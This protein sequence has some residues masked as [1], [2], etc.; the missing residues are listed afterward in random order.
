MTAGEELR[1]GGTGAAPEMVLRSLAP[2]DDAE[3][4]RIHTSA[5]VVRWW[6]EPEDGLRFN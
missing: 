1:L 3:L 4:L 5:E 6:D 2:G